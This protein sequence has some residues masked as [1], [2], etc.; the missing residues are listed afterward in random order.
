ML[1]DDDHQLIMLSRWTG[2]GV[3]V[4]LIGGEREYGG[5]EGSREMMAM[6]GWFEVDSDTAGGNSK[7]KQIL[8]K[9]ETQKSREKN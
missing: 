7:G 6:P 5:Q 9:A 8:G 1:A 2:R 3:S 4:R